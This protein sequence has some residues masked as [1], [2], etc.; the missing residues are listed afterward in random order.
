MMHWSCLDHDCGKMSEA[1]AMSSYDNDEPIVEDVT[2]KNFE[3]SPQSTSRPLLRSKK[4]HR[5]APKAPRG[6][7]TRPL[8]T[9]C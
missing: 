3:G 4:T 6:A 7:P 5:P 2:A 8:P 1:V 9:S